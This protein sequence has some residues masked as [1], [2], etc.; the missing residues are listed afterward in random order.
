MTCKD[1]LVGFNKT[2]FSAIY[3][4]NLPIPPAEGYF[5]SAHIKWACHQQPPS[6]SHGDTIQEL[7]NG[8]PLS[9]YTPSSWDL[10][11]KEP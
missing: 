2:L 9:T 11:Y 8:K 7:V 6:F 3:L 1:F 10:R 5:H 4:I